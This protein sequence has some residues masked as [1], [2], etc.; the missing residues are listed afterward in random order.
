MAPLCTIHTFDPTSDPPPTSSPLHN[1]VIYH[2]D[3]GVG[4]E[5]HGPVVP[6]PKGF[7]IKSI[8]TIMRELGHDKV[9]FLKADVEG[10]EWDMIIKTDWKGLKIGQ[11]ALELHPFG[12]DKPHT[13]M[14]MLHFFDK[15]EDAGYYLASL[16][17]VTSSNFAQVEVVFINK[18]WRPDSW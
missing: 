9:D 16:E 6:P 11:I 3:Y 1:K 4:G 14:D 15:L 8:P 13:A 18:N 7:P 12:D 17:P 10:Y 5:D 2:K